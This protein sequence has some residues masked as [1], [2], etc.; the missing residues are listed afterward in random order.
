MS[1]LGKFTVP[2]IITTTGWIEIEAGSLEEA[3]LEAT[4]LNEEEG[5][6]LDQLEDYS[7]ESECLVDEI[8]QSN[9]LLIQFQK[10]RR[11]K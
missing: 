9:T 8:E 11:P 7:A 4:R 6:S 2:V 10:E 3:K 1:P 5:V